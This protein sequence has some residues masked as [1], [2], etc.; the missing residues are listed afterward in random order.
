MDPVQREKEKDDVVGDQGR[1]LGGDVHSRPGEGGLSR[2]LLLF[3]VAEAVFLGIT[4][5]PD[6][7]AHLAA[8]LLLFLAGSLLSLYAAR[9]L[10]ASRPR[11]LLL[12]AAAFR[13]TL[14]FRQ[15]DLSDDVKRYL[16]DGRVASSGRSPY[17]FA[18]DDP[19]AAGLFPDLAPGLAH[20]EFRTVYPPVAQAAFRAG[21][22]LSETNVLPIKAIFAAADVAV[23]A[24]L[25]ASG[26]AGSG[27]AAALYAF[28]P[29]PVTET[30]GEG[31]LDSLGVALL[32]ASIVYLGRRRHVA[33]GF[34]FAAAVLTKFVPIVAALPLVR[35]GKLR[36]VVTALAAGATLWG[37][38]S[39]D[40]VSPAAGL[41]PYATR[42]E[43]NSVLYP[44]VAGAVDAI[45]LPERAKAAYIRLKERLDHPP[46]TQELFP[47]F[48]AEFFAR[49]LLAI[50]LA[51][52]LVVIAARARDLEGAVFA[53][54]AALLLASPTLHPWY[55]MWVLPFAA[56]RREPAFLYFSFAAPLS[57]ALLYPMRGG[58]APAVLVVE[59]APFAA[60]LGWSLLRRSAPH[61]DPLPRGERE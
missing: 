47:Y 39:R 11:F 52:A 12:C 44:A 29:L 25:L 59:Y 51:I 17:A 34:A 38:A 9:S 2:R 3:A 56:K 1:E 57:Y 58:S 24:L 15:P 18:P 45:D 14:L 54:L 22:T 37:L 4:L 53:S 13:L 48:Y 60:L 43:F 8:Y 19:R 6:A 30:A 7:R 50:G 41:G 32:L 55:L 42:W 33:A 36:F 20:R 46:W 61:P 5:L 10:T 16:W 31:H 35:R 26:G 23:V 40:G 21:A 27:F 49:A 28:H